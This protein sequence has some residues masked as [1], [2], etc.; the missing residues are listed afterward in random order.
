LKNFLLNRYRRK[1]V[2]FICRECGEVFDDPRTDYSLHD[3]GEG[4]AR[5][6]YNVCPACGG[7]DI[8]EA[9]RCAE[10]GVWTP[11]SELHGGLCDDCLAG[12]V[13]VE[14]VFDYADEDTSYDGVIYSLLSDEEITEILLDAAKAKA[15]LGDVTGMKAYAL[16]DK[17]AFGDFLRRRAV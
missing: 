16:E 9:D 8:E 12:K 13:T 17:D 14:N 6:E 11:K 1:K 10:C 4:S 5:E 7:V 2:M 3:F 15:K